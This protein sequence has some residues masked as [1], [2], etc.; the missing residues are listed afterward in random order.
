MV[1]YV[2]NK[3]QNGVELYFPIKPAQSFIDLL[4]AG[5]WRWNRT[6]ECWYKKQTPEAIEFARKAADGT[7]QSTPKTR[8][9][10]NTVVNEHGVEVGDIFYTSWGYEQTNVDFFQV[11]A[12]TAKMATVR[13]ISEKRDETDWAQGKTLPDKDNFV[14]KESR[15]RTCNK[16]GG[17]RIINADGSHDAHFHDGAPVSWSAYY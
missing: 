8:T 4:K 3:A 17:L 7:L 16:Y 11:T 14:G 2:L 10:V 9:S 15:R 1:T 6:K 5:K 12:V 13:K